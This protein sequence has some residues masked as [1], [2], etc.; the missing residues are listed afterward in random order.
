MAVPNLWISRMRTK[1]S[2]YLRDLLGSAV[3]TES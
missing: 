3:A 1:V 2:L